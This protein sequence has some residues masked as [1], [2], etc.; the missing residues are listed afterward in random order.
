MQKNFFTSK[1]YQVIHQAK[2]LN[3]LVIGDS[4]VDRFYYGTCDRISPE[5]PVPVL[6]FVRSELMPGMAANVAENAKAFT[7]S[8][9]LSTQK[10]EI[11]KTRFV[12]EKTKQHIMR[13]DEENTILSRFKEDEINFNEYDV[14]LVSDYG[15]GFLRDFSTK[16]IELKNKLFYVDTKRSDLSSFANSIIKIN[17]KESNEINQKTLDDTSM[18]I[19]TLGSKGA[20]FKEKIYETNKVDIFDV[21]GAGDTFLVA[22][23]VYHYLTQDIDDA[24]GFANKC[25]CLV[26]QRPGTSP[27]TPQLLN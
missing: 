20:K 21:S 15:K 22:F 4:C 2:S 23:A 8:V 3:I 19:V 6:K 7:D 11:T 13:F 16:G 5:A 14:V 18:I 17:E 27:L 25:A 26:V 9:E 12:D 24:I 10:E 1:E